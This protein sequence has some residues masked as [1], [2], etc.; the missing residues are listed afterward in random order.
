MVNKKAGASD[1]VR[2]PRKIGPIVT[3]RM[4]VLILSSAVGGWLFYGVLTRLPHGSATFL[5]AIMA[6]LFSVGMGGGLAHLVGVGARAIAKAVAGGNG[7][8]RKPAWNAR[9]ETKNSG[10]G[11]QRGLA[12]SRGR[13]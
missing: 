1:T 7:G 9:M 12:R 5:L 3:S 10:G 8:L 11:P 4:V 6:F 13:S 2:F